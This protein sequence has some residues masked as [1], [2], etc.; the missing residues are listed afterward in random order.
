MSNKTS[1]HI[2]GSATNLL[3]FCLIILSSIHIA[4]KNKNTYADEFVSIVAL[5]LTVS[6]IL[7]FVSIKTNNP[8]KAVS[9]EKYADSLFLLA[10]FGIFAIILGLVFQF[11]T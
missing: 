10:L 2:L 5:M 1:Q 8:R 11:W 3:G 4:E 7:S 9:L 6:C